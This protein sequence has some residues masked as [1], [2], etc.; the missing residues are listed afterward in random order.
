M[1]GEGVLVVAADRDGNGAR[2]RFNALR[3]KA[4]ENACRG[5]TRVWLRDV[6]P[7]SPPIDTSPFPPPSLTP[8][9]SNHLGPCLTADTFR[10]WRLS[11]N[12]QWLI[13]GEMAH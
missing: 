2:I 8:S 9:P 6:T 12:T 11:S 5:C 4:D 3:R 7:L 13:S 10:V 1:R